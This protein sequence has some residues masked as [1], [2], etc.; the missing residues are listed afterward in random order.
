M[1]TEAVELTPRQVQA[2]DDQRDLGPSGR[3]AL[4]VA[5]REVFPSGTWLL[6][7]AGGSGT[8]VPALRATGSRVVVVDWSWAMLGAAS[9]R[10]AHRCCGDLRRLPFPDVVFGG[11]HAAYAIQ[12][13]TQ[14][15]D[16]IG[17]CVRVAGAAAPVVVAWGGPP[18]DER[19][20]GIEGAYFAAVGAAMGVRGQ[21]TGISVEAAGEHFASLGRPLQRTFAVEGEQ[22]R[23]PRQVI[24]RASLNPFRSQP[25]DATRD[26]AVAVA[27]GWA[28]E[29]VGPV[30]APVRFR[31]Q[32]VHHVYAAPRG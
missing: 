19:L 3:A 11:V 20:A 26:R 7:A 28:Q 17:E 5:Y 24:E 21:R 23:T 12:N 32:P 14:W 29:H 27:L 4:E 1:S 10:A 31:T 18:A 2:H 9:G 15:R 8:A 22:V 16:A 13:V 6:D 25:D 30:D